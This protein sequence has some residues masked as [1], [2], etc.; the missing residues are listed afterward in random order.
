MNKIQIVSA[1][2]VL[3]SSL[4]IAEV[5][6]ANCF[7]DNMVLQR[8][9]EVPIWGTADSGERIRVEFAGQAKT[10]TADSD[11]NWILT[12]DPLEVSTEGRQL[13][14][15]SSTST[16]QI[17]TFSNILV[18][19]VWLCS[20]QSNMMYTLEKDIQAAT[21]IPQSV[22]PNIR[23]LQ[24][25]WQSSDTPLSS[26]KSSN[27]DENPSWVEATS[28]TSGKFTAVGYWFAKDIAAST[29]V[30]VGLIPAY[31]GG[32]PVEA[33]LPK[34]ALLASDGGK[35]V[36]DHYVAALKVFP[37]KYEV[38]LKDMEA[39]RN[40]VQGMTLEERNKVK[41]P[42]MPYG[43]LD[44]NH[45]CGLYY[46]SVVP[47]QPMAIKGVLWYQGESNA[48]SPMHKAVNYE[49]TFTN[50]IRSWRAAWGREDLPFLFVQLPSFRAVSPEPEDSVWSRVRN[51][52][53][54]TLAL[55]H[56]GMAI[57]LDVGNEKDIHP[58]N[59]QPVGD[60]LAQWAKATVYGMD[61]VPSGPLYES[62]EI[63]GDTV[64]ITFKHA[65]K[66]LETRDVSLIGGHELSGS[67]LLGF[68]ISGDDEQFVH[69]E[70]KITAP[71][72][73]TVHSPTIRN[74]EAV[75]YAWSSFPLS[76]LYNKDGLPASS[77]RTDDFIPQSLKNR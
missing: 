43:P 31:K 40:Q 27:R 12:L 57:T 65:G 25:A 1:A 17:T 52:Q 47:Y 11:G 54:R 45:P 51:A 14:L 66:G 10:A 13:A 26:L 71:N 37:E 16:E 34:E 67:T 28:E 72:Q 64:V 73:V 74:P 48:C 3:I 68:T 22:N 15:S 33:W 77:F 61:M 60:R 38:Y 46:G 19:D 30:P 50:L 2:W 49:S 23:F 20:G 42:R 21:E 44:G 6:V 41:R 36:W 58:K 29:G 8:E 69:A 35:V 62:M 39:W 18:G 55:P 76:N 56:T 70:A 4:A 9:V 7:T 63:R 75:R 5:Q 59:K 53:T 24:V 32:S